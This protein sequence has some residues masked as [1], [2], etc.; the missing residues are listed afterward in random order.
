MSLL[1]WTGSGTTSVLSTAAA[2]RL[3]LLLIL[4][5]TIVLCLAVIAVLLVI[6]A[7]T[8]GRRTARAPTGARS[9]PPAAGR[10]RGGVAAVPA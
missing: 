7:V 10:E 2:Y 6:S 9:L 3:R 8:A 4:A 5:G 1:D